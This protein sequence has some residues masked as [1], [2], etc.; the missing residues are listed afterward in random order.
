[1]LGK[2]RMKSVLFGY[3][4]RSTAIIS[5]GIVHSTPKQKSLKL[6]RSELEKLRKY[7]NLSDSET[8]R[9]WQESYGRYMRMSKDSYSLLRR[10]KNEAEIRAGTDLDYEELLKIR[11]NVVYGV[12][13]KEFPIL[14]H[15]K[16]EIA[17][18]YE[19]RGKREYLQNLT[20]SGVFY[21]CSS[22]INPAKDHADWE[23]KIYI[24]AD[25]TSRC[26]PDM[27][28]KIEA[29]VRNHD[30]R[31][32]EWVTG[33]PVYLVTRP[34]CKHYLIEIPIEEVLSSSVNKLLKAHDMYME[35]EKELSYEE[36]QYKHYYE[37][38][39]VYS[40]L[41]NM[42]D[43]ED[44]NKDITETRKLVRKW[45]LLSEGSGYRINSTYRAKTSREA[46]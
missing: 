21:L 15:T 20:N 4:V 27:H 28:G 40:Y 31:T 43:A 29:Y 9:L 1:M 35:D 25:W 39:K 42:F 45:K 8:N 34:N 7:A 36:T 41:H 24:A 44:L 17:D 11:K 33:E 2:S 32:V 46:A 19:Y 13:K 38:L 18:E 30:I 37:R 12:S 6:M 3:E 16:N 22:H 23:G 5:N 26:D 14:E 10:A